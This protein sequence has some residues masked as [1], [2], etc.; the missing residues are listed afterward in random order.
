MRQGVPY[1]WAGFALPYA[2]VGIGVYLFKSANTALFI[3]YPGIILFVWT[4]QR[5]ELTRSLARGWNWGYGAALSIL[6]ALGG[7]VVFLLWPYAARE[8]IDL[9]TV[10]AEY[11]LAGAKGLAFACVAVLLN[12]CLEELFWRGCFFDSVNRPSVIDIAFGGYH[13]MVL[14]LVLQWWAAVSVVLM[15]SAASWVLRYAKHHCGGLAVP[16][17]AHAAADLSIVL[18]VWLLVQR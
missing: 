14:L 1:T 13:G 11:G 16:C 7:V 8:G 5:L 4:T 2:A 6:F 9:A 10:L 17:V 12:P 18:S 3:Y 15:L